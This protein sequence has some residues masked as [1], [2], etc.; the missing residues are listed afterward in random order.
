MTSPVG[1]PI[2][3]KDEKRIIEEYVR[4]HGNA[5]TGSHAR[6][7]GKKFTELKLITLEK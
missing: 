2:F 1:D 6:H 7:G 3:T 5:A 4:E